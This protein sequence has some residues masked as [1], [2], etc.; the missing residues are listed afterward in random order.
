[1]AGSEFLFCWGAEGGWSEGESTSQ[2]DWS[3]EGLCFFGR[4]ESPGVMER[5][6]PRDGTLLSV[7]AVEAAEL[8]MRR[9][10]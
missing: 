5:F 7:S 8:D 4:G 1:M 10:S 9:E 3:T 2:L 6:S